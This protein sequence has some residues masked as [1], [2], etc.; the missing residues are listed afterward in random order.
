MPQDNNLF[1]PAN[2][3]PVTLRNRTIRSAAFEGMGKDNNPTEQLM[4]YHEAVAK[5]GVGMTTVAY[6]GI[7][8]SAL[9]FDSLFF[10]KNL[11]C[12]CAHLF[13]ICQASHL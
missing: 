6:A 9:S 2:I 12:P 1:T 4:A 13:E 5:G 8:K 10:I 3:G 11:V 7:C